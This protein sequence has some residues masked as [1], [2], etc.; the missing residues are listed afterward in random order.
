MR[1]LLTLLFVAGCLSAAAT[2]IK[3]QSKRGL[4]N[5][6]TSWDLNRLPKAGDTVIIQPK[7]TLVID[8]NLTASNLRIEVQGVIFFT[9]GGSKLVLDESSTIAVAAG[10]TIYS[11]KNASQIISIGDV[12][13]YGGNGEVVTGP[14]FASNSTQGFTSP[15]ILPVKFLG[16]SAARQNADVLVQ[17]STSQEVNADF[18]EVQR[19]ED[20]LNWK[21]V[22]KVKAV[23]AARTTSNYSFVD[24]NVTQ[25]TAYYRIKQVD[26]DTRFEY[27][28]V[29]TVKAEGNGLAVNAVAVRGNIVLQFSKQVLGQVEVRLVS[30]NGQVVSRQLLNRPVGQLIIPAALK[31][32]FILTVSDQQDIQ[33]NKQILL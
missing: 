8:R 22:G 33:V 14:A 30:L 20:G 1:K 27:T 10:G 7:D 4:W 21:A 29:R 25:K 16:F 3:S 24:R 18:Y 17:W 5:Q 13:Q 2:P 9:G 12:Q 28:A 11:D 26:L 19:S 23:G 32:N 15:I 6:S 31:G